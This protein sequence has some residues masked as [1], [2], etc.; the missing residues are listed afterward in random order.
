MFYARLATTETHVTNDDIMGIDLER[1]ARDADAVARCCLAGNGDIRSLHIDRSL[2]TDD[3]RDI[4]YHDACSTC[5]TS[6]AEGTRAAIIQVG[7]DKDLAA[8]ASESEHTAAFCSGESR[9]LGL[10]QFIRT[11]CPLDERTSVTSFFFDDR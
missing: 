7:H 2:E 3:T 10:G 6:L 4:E 5:L 8:T 11:M 9:N 1:F